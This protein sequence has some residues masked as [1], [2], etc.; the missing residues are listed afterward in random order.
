M[1]SL[2]Y[3]IVFIIILTIPSFSGGS[4]SFEKVKP[5][6]ETNP[7]LWSYL[8][9]SFEFQEVGS[10]KRFG[11][12]WE[13]LGGKRLCPYI[14]P[15]TSKIDKKIHFDLQINCKQTFY[16]KNK[17]VLPIN[18]KKIENKFFKESASFTEKLISVTILPQEKK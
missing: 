17:K 8:N 16:D 13:F 15:V 2:Y 6:L 1:K 11:R 3:K 9:N 10:A 12:Q 5:L 4:V 14:F 7:T 18:L